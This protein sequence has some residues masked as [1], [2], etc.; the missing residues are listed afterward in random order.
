MLLN[1]SDSSTKLHRLQ[2]IRTEE[3]LDNGN[4]DSES[5]DDR[6]QSG[7]EFEL[8]LLEP[9]EKG[10]KE[11]NEQDKEGSKK[12]R[13]SQ[14]GP[15]EG[16]VVA[17]KSKKS[18]K[19]RKI[20]SPECDNENNLADSGS[21][22]GGGGAL[23]KK[24]KDKKVN[25]K[26]VSKKSKKNEDES[27][28]NANNEEMEDNAFV[29][30]S[31]TIGGNSESNIYHEEDRGTETVISKSKDI[32]VDPK[33]IFRIE[34]QGEDAEVGESD[35]LQQKRIDIQQ[36]FA[37]DDVVEQFVKEKSDLEEASK[38]KDIDLSLPGWGCWAG[39][40]IKPSERK[41]KLFT[42]KADPA[43][44]R[45]DKDLAHVIINEE[46]SKFFAR[47]QVWNDS[48]YNRAAK[49]VC[50][51]IKYHYA[52]LISSVFLLVR[53][54]MTSFPALSRRLCSALSIVCAN[55]RLKMANDR[56]VYI[57]KKKITR[58]R[59]D[60]SFCFQVLKTILGTFSRDDDDV[61]ENET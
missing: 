18:Q 34:D 11:L 19:A 32:H 12:K 40:G 9:A 6:E 57:I 29:D 52:L 5:G 49:A 60:T 35:S 7:D 37:N 24:K 30:S 36:A 1:H 26:K 15:K 14:L 53:I 27:T 21:I 28:E 44:P 22:G 59:E 46:K 23:L 61:D 33:K 3:V 48:S 20:N 31:L 58:W 42:K 43:P 17:K 45:K 10:K 55:S 50:C 39:E 4:E 25:K 16:D 41:K 13:K 8:K 2:P 56:F 54:L 38:P 47:N 51:I